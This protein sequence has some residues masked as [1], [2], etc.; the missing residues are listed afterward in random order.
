MLAWL[1]A[2]AVLSSK[3]ELQT[4]IILFIFVMTAIAGSGQ[5]EALREQQ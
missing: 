5:E 4:F 2:H 3:T 1:F